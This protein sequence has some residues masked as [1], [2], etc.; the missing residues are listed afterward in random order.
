MN[1]DVRI[2]LSGINKFKENNE[3][4]SNFLKTFEEAMTVTNE[5]VA[6][7][8]M[9]L[10]CAHKSMQQF[11]PMFLGSNKREH[12]VTLYEFL[13]QMEMAINGAGSLLFVKATMLIKG[14]EKSAIDES[15][16]VKDGKCEENMIDYAKN[17]I[18][19]N[20]E[21]KLSRLDYQFL[22]W[23]D[24]T[25]LMNCALW[26]KGIRMPFGEETMKIE[27]LGTE[28]IGHKDDS[29]SQKG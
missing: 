16:I 29:L 7:K 1:E 5:D 13:Q 8:L 10:F 19:A 12:L 4:I 27:K 28:I 14:D 26:F 22:T 6:F 18:F 2:A 15:F 24:L 23:K 17:E 20:V 11:M 9:N 3:E 25:L 21:G